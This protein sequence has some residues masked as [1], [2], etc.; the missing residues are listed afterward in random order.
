MRSLLAHHKDLLV[1]SMAELEMLDEKNRRLEEIHQIQS[2]FVSN[3]THELRTPLNTML[4]VAR[5]VMGD[6]ELPGKHLRHME[7]LLKRGQDLLGIV[8]NMLDLSKLES[9]AMT[10]FV[11]D[12]ELG[13]LL[14][15][16]LHSAEA[17]VG[18][19]PVRFQ[20]SL[21]SLP[22]AFPTDPV[23]LGRIL[24][25]LLA[26][27]VKF[28]D[29]GMIT[30]AATGEGNAV[31][32]AVRDT[33][34]GIRDEDLERLFTKFTQ[35]ESTKT[36]RHAGT[37]LGLVIVKGLVDQLGGTI[38][39]ESRELQGTTFTVRLTSPRPLELRSV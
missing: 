3:M 18:G 35:L 26:N 14:E 38:A 4:G 34:V 19:K 23:L 39:V 36:K 20:L 27:A 8:N 17:L 5:A 2:E 28:T 37:G 31:R 29:A 15:D 21:Q 9:G 16:Q 7:L 30:L 33:G 13:T 24:S 12:V 10:P 6:P 22:R 32:I 11:E 1:S 25:N